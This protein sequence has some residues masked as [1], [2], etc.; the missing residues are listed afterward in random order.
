MGLERNAGI[1]PDVEKLEMVG[2]DKSGEPVRKCAI[3]TCCSDNWLPFA[4]VALLGAKQNTS[5][6]PDLIV[7]TASDA[8]PQY[9]RHFAEF[10]QLHNLAVQLLKMNVNDLAGLDSGALHYSTLFRLALDRALDDSYDRVLYLDADILVLASIDHLFS[11]DLHGFAAAAVP[12]IGITLLN[13]GL[14]SRVLEA[15][16]HAGGENYFNAGVLLMDW[17]VFVKRGILSNALQ[18]LAS[19]KYPLADQDALNV[20]LRGD[21]LVLPYEFNV[22]SAVAELW[23][24]RP[25]I[26][27]FTAE[28]PWSRLYRSKDAA[29]RRHYKSL[30]PADGDIRMIEPARLFELAAFRFKRFVKTL[31]R[32]KA[33]GFGP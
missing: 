14:R 4:A 1:S 5:H 20:V 24:V 29:Y 30:L 18:R 22:T 7:V 11:C 10:C 15:T 28:K 8:R 17:K 3:V 12:D 19:Q 32:R 27:H 6:C 21:W 23:N 33:A 25:V 13:T 31:K 9:L 16:G 26:R 2:A